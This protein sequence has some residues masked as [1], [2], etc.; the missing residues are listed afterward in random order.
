MPHPPAPQASVQDE[1]CVGMQ[2]SLRDAG[3]AALASQKQL[4]KCLQDAT[5]TSEKQRSEPRLAEP[6]VDDTR[7][8]NGDG[9]GR[10][11]EVLRMP[12]GAK[13]QLNV[14][15]L[16]PWRLY[17]RGNREQ[18]E[19][20]SPNCPDMPVVKRRKLNVKTRSQQS[21][22][23]GWP[24]NTLLY[25]GQPLKTDYWTMISYEIGP[26]GKTVTVTAPGKKPFCITIGPGGKPVTRM[27][28][29]GK[30]AE[31]G[32]PPPPPP[33][34]PGKGQRQRAKKRGKLAPVPK[35]PES[36]P[37][38]S[39]APSDPNTKKEPKES[40]KVACPKPE[41]IPKPEPSVAAGRAELEAKAKEQ[42]KTQKRRLDQNRQN[43]LPR[44]SERL[45]TALADPELS[46]TVKPRQ[47]MNYA[48]LTIPYSCSTALTAVKWRGFLA[49]GTRGRFV[50]NLS[51]AEVPSPRYKMPMRFKSIC[52]SRPK[53][54]NEDDDIAFRLCR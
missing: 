26:G 16:M 46:R 9:G 45:I 53:E 18:A 36:K 13:R 34:S 35:S 32:A 37:S 51:L 15:C 54:Q 4:G 14:D 19:A 1:G 48:W 21:Q 30:P 43:R 22:E 23:P 10:D 25:P 47:G 38:V 50:G 2:E 39:K 24:D 42:R 11:S 40:S 20:A 5:I 3:P 27:I 29:E 8:G 17:E 31:L 49:R 7:A 44:L 41:A 28:P 6:P 33:R 52:G 12:R